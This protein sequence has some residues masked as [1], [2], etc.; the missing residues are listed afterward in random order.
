MAGCANLLIVVDLSTK[1]D[2]ASFRRKAKRRGLVVESLETGEARDRPWECPEHRSLRLRRIEKRGGM[3]VE[4]FGPDG[5]VHYTRP[6]GH[7]DI[8]E[9]MKTP[10]YGVRLVP[11]DV[12]VSAPAA[13]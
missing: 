6:A 5:K 2:I 1:A 7:P 8:A 13:P 12:K 9:A 4:I 3:T 11:G 10:G